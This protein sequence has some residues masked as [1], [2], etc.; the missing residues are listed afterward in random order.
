MT[1]NEKFN[2]VRAR[3]DAAGNVLLEIIDLTTSFVLLSVRTIKSI[4]KRKGQCYTFFSS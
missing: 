2:A 1:P 3:P 4:S